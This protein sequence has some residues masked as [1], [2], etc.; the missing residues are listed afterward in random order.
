M[1]T[2]MDNESPTLMPSDLPTL[3][4]NA[5]AGEPPAIHPVDLAWS[6]ADT[7]EIQSA[8]RRP[9]LLAALIVLLALVCLALGA[10]GVALTKVHQARPPVVTPASVPPR[11]AAVATG[12]KAYYVDSALDEEF[13]TRITADGFPF[14]PGIPAAAEVIV[15]AHA[16]CGDFNEL[17]TQLAT[18]VE[19][20]FNGNT[21]QL[22]WT[23]DQTRAFVHD[24]A[25]IHCPQVLS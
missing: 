9:L 24:A 14:G 15:S 18:E 23:L 13:L 17:H 1:L 20:V 8:P 10:L 25:S 5:P 16:V 11:P 21:K 6:T 22:G 19:S 3:V 4:G 7:E 12:P 2:S